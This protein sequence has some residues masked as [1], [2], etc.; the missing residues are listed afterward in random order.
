MFIGRVTGISPMPAGA[1]MPAPGR[2]GEILETLQPGAV[3]I[4]Q[5]S[6]R[7]ERGIA[8]AAVIQHAGGIAASAGN[9]SS[10]RPQ[11]AWDC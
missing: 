1:V 3:A 2:P 10:E 7:V 4:A 11:R 8:D 6:V 5:P 9:T